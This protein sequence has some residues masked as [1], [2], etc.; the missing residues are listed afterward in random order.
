MNPLAIDK[1]IATLD[2]HL[3]KRPKTDAV[4]AG[5]LRA[6]LR[7]LDEVNRYVMRVDDRTM[8]VR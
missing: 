3:A 4:T 1:A 7:I 6:V 2:G 5:E 8:V